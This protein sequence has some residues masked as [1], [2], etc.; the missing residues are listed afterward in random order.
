[1]KKKLTALVLFSILALPVIAQGGVLDVD[2]PGASLTLRGVLEKIVSAF[3]LVFL[4]LAVIMF[5][6]AGIS[7]ITAGG[8]P[9]KLSTARGYFL[10][11]IAG[12]IVAILGYSIVYL[13]KTYLGA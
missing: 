3:W 7:F 10:W 5:I 9:D 4:A 1:M 11:G 6:L 13:V 8:D 12:V 2:E